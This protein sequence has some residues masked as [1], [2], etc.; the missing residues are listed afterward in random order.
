VLKLGLEAKTNLALKCVDAKV[1]TFRR[2]G[3]VFDDAA[4]L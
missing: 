3:K 1:G 4:E 2:L